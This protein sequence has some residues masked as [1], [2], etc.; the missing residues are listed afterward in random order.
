MFTQPPHLFQLLLCVCMWGTK[1]TSGSSVTHCVC[2][3]KTNVCHQSLSV[4]V[5]LYPFNTTSVQ[6]WHLLTWQINP[7]ILPTFDTY[8][9]VTWFQEPK[10]YIHRGHRVVGWMHKWY[11]LIRSCN[12][13]HWAASKALPTLQASLEWNTET[14]LAQS[15]WRASCKQTPL[16]QAIIPTC[17]Y[18]C[19]YSFF[20]SPSP[21]ASLNFSLHELA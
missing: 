7:N 8:R 10:C 20:H 9:W 15:V 1:K 13:T 18:D 11:L 2:T 12:I 21:K 6:P 4:C 16:R 3:S 19:V 14:Q 17:L 5:S